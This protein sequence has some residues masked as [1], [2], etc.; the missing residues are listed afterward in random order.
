MTKIADGKEIR[1]YVRINVI[2]KGG[3]GKTSLVHR[4]LGRN[5]EGLISTDG[6][7]IH[8]SCQIKTSN[9]EWV[10]GKGKSDPI[11]IK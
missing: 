5:I 7:E 11:D 9:G 10:V 6:I 2:G 3:V 8:K 1:K 4:L